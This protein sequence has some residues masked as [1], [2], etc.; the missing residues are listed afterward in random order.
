MKNKLTLIELLAIIAVIAILASMLLPA[1]N[2]ARIR[3]RVTT[4]AG[5]LKQIGLA[6]ISYAQGS[7]DNF[8]D[9]IT[10]LTT[11]YISADGIVSVDG[12][13]FTMIAGIT[14]D[15]TATDRVITDTSIAGFTNTLYADGHVVTRNG[16]VGVANPP[17]DISTYTRPTMFADSNV[18]N[19]EF[20]DTS[21]EWV[22]GEEGYLLATNV[23]GDT[24]AFNPPDGA[25][26]LQMADGADWNF[27]IDETQHGVSIS[28]AGD[29]MGMS[30]G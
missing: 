27:V 16:G 28:T 15:S 25:E 26:F 22:G 17:L 12:N 8:P 24:Y 29:V 6:C 19:S 2:Q 20:G 7:E 3:A 21:L 14:T 23:L 30:N 13:P 10:V 18:I 5:R 4:N 9:T 1:I 11:S